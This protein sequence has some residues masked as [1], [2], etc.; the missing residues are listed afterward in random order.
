MHLK[1]V[2][3]HLRVSLNFSGVLPRTPVK[4][5]RDSRK[6]GQ[7][8]E[9]I[10]REQKERKGAGQGKREGGRELRYSSPTDKSWIRHCT[11]FEGSLQI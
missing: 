2:K 1:C 8:I 4:R 9:D 6:G 11:P 3:T 10:D 7:G 5:R